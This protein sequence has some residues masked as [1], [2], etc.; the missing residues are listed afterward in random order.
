MNI[1]TK[2]KKD[3]YS[4]FCK[5]I[6]IL[7]LFLVSTKFN[8]VLAQTKPKHT[9][10]TENPIESLL[11]VGNSFFYYNNSIH[12]HVDKL[13]KA[14]EPSKKTRTTSI[15]ISGSSIDWHDMESYLRSDTIGKYSIDADNKVVF[16]KPGRMFDAVIMMD[17]SLCPLHPQLKSIFHEYIKKD[18]GIILKAGAQ[19]ILFMTW[20][21]KDKP[22]MTA[23]LAE[24]YTIAG[25]DNN[26]LIIPAGLSFSKAISKRPDLELYQ[27]D[28]R[29][30][31]L[32]GTYLAACTTYEA[33][34]KKSPIGN[35]YIA[36][37]KPQDAEFLQKIAHETVQE[38]F[39]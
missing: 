25:N 15:T 10:L 13:V 17:C 32:L 5:T 34:Y 39:G 31:T 23:Q 16:R 35:T 37:I 6:V 9:K 29:H 11:W 27:S 18:S 8:I 28:N 36:G 24:Q 20:A 26:A 3:G 14:S 30:P 4:P 22:E 12:I 1:S 7:T 33:I 2:I 38:Y 21:Y 19:P